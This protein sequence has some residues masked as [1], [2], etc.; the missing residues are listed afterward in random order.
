MIELARKSEQ[1]AFQRVDVQEL[2]RLL[3]LSGMKDEKPVM[4]RF[5]AMLKEF[6]KRH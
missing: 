1:K 2:E 5:F 4:H 6:F 3:K